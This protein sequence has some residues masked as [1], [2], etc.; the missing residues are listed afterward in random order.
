[1]NE[2]VSPQT[3]G[4]ER[5]YSLVKILGIWVAAAVPMASLAVGGLYLLAGRGIHRSI[6][7]H[8]RDEKGRQCV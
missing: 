2:N 4:T 7:P 5:Q 8:R 1:M 6:H 3:V